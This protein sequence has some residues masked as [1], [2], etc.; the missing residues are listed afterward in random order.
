MTMS[1]VTIIAGCDEPG[2]AEKAGKKIDET[3]EKMGDRIDDAVTEPGPAEKAGE[4]IDEA[5]EATKEE[6][7]DAKQNIEQSTQ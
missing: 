7:K 2:P 4:Q 3:V 6:L 1:L 5:V